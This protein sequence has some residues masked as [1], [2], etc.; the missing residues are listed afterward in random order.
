MKRTVE[1]YQWSEKCE[2]DD[3]D[4]K[5]CTYEKVW[6]EGLIDSSEFEQNGHDNPTTV[7]YESEVYVSNN[8]RLGAYVLPED[9]I[10]KLSYN[11]KKDNDDLI[12]EYQNPVEGIVIDGVY[13]TNV[14][15]IGDIRISYQYLDSETVSVMAVQSGDTFEA[16][17]SK[18][19]KD[20]YKIMK[21][22]YTG[23]QILEGMTKNNN[24]LKWIL[25]FVGVLLIISAFSSM[26]SFIT[27]LA[28]KVPILGNIVS[29]ATGLVSAVLGFAVSLIVIAI[30]WFRFRPILSICLVLV[31]VILI[32][33]LKTNVLDK[34]KNKDSK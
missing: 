7:L 9:L 3:D 5:K 29:G 14:P 8:V 12:S 18:T 34:F 23:A 21:G 24:T 16:F 20:V 17:T 27:N 33:C 2:T 13:L 22:S 10:Q 11:K 15:E 28:N 30:A 4:N 6:E 1:I 32:V 26:F 31:V 25:R 19:G